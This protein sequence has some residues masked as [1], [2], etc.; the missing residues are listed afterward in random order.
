MGAVLIWLCTASSLDCKEVWRLGIRYIQPEL[1]EGCESSG[2]TAS[3][4]V[5]RQHG[6]CQRFPGSLHVIATWA[7]SEL[8]P[9]RIHQGK[10]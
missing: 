5:L 10:S 1:Q 9:L 8:H 2:I 4:L 3:V 6:D 7:K